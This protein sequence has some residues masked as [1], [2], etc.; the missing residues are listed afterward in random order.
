VIVIVGL[1]F[2]CDCFPL[3]LFFFFSQVRGLLP[4]F[5]PRGYPFPLSAVRGTGMSRGPSDP[6]FFFFLPF[7]I[8]GLFFLPSEFF[9]SPVAGFRCRWPSRGGAGLGREI[10]PVSYSL[11]RIPFSLSPRRGPVLFFSHRRLF[12]VF[13]LGSK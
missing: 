12:F 7:A 6:V 11:T 10:R 8:T 5:L 3:W 2:S 13:F 4:S 9:L 1:F